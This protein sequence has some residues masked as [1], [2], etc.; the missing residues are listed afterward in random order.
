MKMKVAHF[1]PLPPQQTGIADY[2]AALIP[3]L[4]Q[5]MDLTLFCDPMEAKRPFSTLPTA[6]FPFHSLSVDACL[7]HM[8]NHPR[9]HHAIWKM[10]QRYPGIVV[11][12]EIDLFAFFTQTSAAHFVREMGYG[13]GI[14]GI[15]QARRCLHQGEDIVAG[16][17]P[18]KFL[19]KRIADLSLGLI[20]HTNYAQRQLELFTNTPVMTIPLGTKLAPTAEATAVQTPIRLGVFGV[21]AASKRIEPLLRAVAKIRQTAPPFHLYFSGPQLPDFPLQEIVQQHGVEEIVFLQDYLSP[22]EFEAQ[23][24]Q[25]DIAIN[26]RAAPTGGE[27][28]ATLVR[29]LAYGKP[30]LVSAVGGFNDV[31]QTAVVHI[32][33][34]NQEVEH[35][36]TA[37]RTLMQDPQKRR[38]LSQA[39]RHYA[40]NELNFTTI[41][42]KYREFLREIL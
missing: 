4:Q 22:A 35:I 17:G 19:L 13:A 40:Q 38:T 39:A 42:K 37:L 25:V 15:H 24:Q 28:S 14:N 1:S 26:L 27:M 7:Y 18:R 5:E 29:L 21:M 23:L 34:D 10:L 9:H 32:P 11:L 30:V 31:P 2:C 3:H 12:H 20:V 36:A 8:G 16:S 41:A 6:T 33:Q